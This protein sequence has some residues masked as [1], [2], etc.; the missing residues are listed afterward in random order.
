MLYHLQC[1]RALARPERLLMRRRMLC[2][3]PHFFS[4][5]EV[6]C[7]DDFWAILRFR[8]QSRLRC[9]GERAGTLEPFPNDSRA[10][11]DPGPQI[12]DQGLEMGESTAML[13]R[14]LGVS[15]VVFF[16]VHLIF[17]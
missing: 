11:L 6:C 14:C 4:T 9:D 13:V 16:L 1:E 17:H 7:Q 5:R 8:V 15:L 12:R 2:S 10:S 3:Y